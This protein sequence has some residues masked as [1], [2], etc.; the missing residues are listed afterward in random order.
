MPA[1]ESSARTGASMAVAAILCVQLGLAASVGLFDRVGPEGAACLRLTWA[2]LLLVV[3]VRPRRSQF[4]RSGF[5][6]SLLHGAAIAGV[7]IFFM[8]AVARLPLGTAS[9]LEF[10]GPLG[11]A[12]APGHPGPVV[13]P[14]IAGG[15]GLL[16]ADR[17]GRR[18]PADRAV[19][20]YGG[21]RRCRPR[22]GCGGLLGGVHPA[23][24]AGRR[25]G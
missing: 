7:T 24:P 16:P 9:A 6:C 3:L 17:G 13:W 18:A 20:R 15:G 5:R 11:V 19:G 21:P 23:H 14:P 4:T 2:G 25:R 8:A 12:V 1:S 10:L 22:A